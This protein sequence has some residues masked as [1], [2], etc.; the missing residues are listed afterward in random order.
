MQPKPATVV[1]PHRE[2]G[3]QAMLDA[4]NRRIRRLRAFNAVL[5][6]LALVLAVYGLC[7]Q[8]ANNDEAAWSSV[9]P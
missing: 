3:L 4:E 5:I 9:E 2:D 8:I 6:T 1:I 7:A